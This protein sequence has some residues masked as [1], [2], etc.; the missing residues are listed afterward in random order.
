MPSPEG[1]MEYGLNPYNY[2]K[3][4]IKRYQEKKMALSDRDL[5]F[6]A[7]DCADRMSIGET[8]YFR[9]RTLALRDWPWLVS[10]V[11][12]EAAGRLERII[13]YYV[14]QKDNEKAV[15]MKGQ[16]SKSTEPK[17]RTI[18]RK[19]MDR[20]IEKILEESKKILIRRK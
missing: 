16:K 3:D 18:T 8:R 17:L 15:R 1:I 5:V 20:E 2:F 19:E 7:W 13:Y 12:S 9:E 11:G 6:I 10:N 14:W 4:I